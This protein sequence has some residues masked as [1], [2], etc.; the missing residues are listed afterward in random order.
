MEYLYC[1]KDNFEDLSSGRVIYGAAGVPNF[2]VRLSNEIYRR[3]A[4]YIPGK[5]KYVVYDPCCGGGYLLTV[6]GFCNQNIAKLIGSDISSEMVET[7]GKNLGLLSCK[8]LEKRKK[9]LEDLFLQYKKDSHAEAVNSAERLKSY[10]NHDME[11]QVFQADCTKPLNRNEKPD[12][13]ITDVPYGNLA[14]WKAVEGDP[15]NAMYDRLA[16]IAHADTILAVIMDK[17]QKY[18]G[19]CWKRLERH[20]IGKRKFEIYEQGRD[21]RDGTD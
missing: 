7:A 13:I 8:G 6:L 16:E 1:E 12:I 4:Q 5:E 17:K 19:N 14:V 9:E 18:Q 2:P 10:I 21:I 3:C 15:L 20:M 11:Y